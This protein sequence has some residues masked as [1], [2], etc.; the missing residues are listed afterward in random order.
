M[1]T[2]NCGSRSSF[3]ASSSSHGGSSATKQQGATCSRRG[4]AWVGGWVSSRRL[5][6]AKTGE[7]GAQPCAAEPQQQPQQQRHTVAGPERVARRGDANCRPDTPPPED[8][9][10]AETEWKGHPQTEPRPQHTPQTLT[11]V[12]HPNTSDRHPQH[13][14][15][16]RSR[17]THPGHAPPPPHPTH[18]S[19]SFPQTH[20]TAASTTHV[21]EGGD[22]V[23]LEP[24]ALQQLLHHHQSCGLGDDGGQLQEHA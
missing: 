5:M 8:S 21:I 9:V 1:L 3:P 7:V 11:N 6:G 13:R 14:T 17:P 24:P 12:R 2:G 18:T 22:G 10:Q 23:E 4:E 15:A 16:T 19:P 20:P